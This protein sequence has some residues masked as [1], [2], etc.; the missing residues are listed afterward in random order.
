VSLPNL[1]AGRELVPEFLQDRATVENLGESVL[2]YLQ[3]P[4]KVAVLADQFLRL[5]QELRRGDAAA[6]A[7]AGLI[8]T[9][10]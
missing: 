2:G 9:G 5:H 6:T 7:I 10:R 4:Q 1:L 8:G 3:H